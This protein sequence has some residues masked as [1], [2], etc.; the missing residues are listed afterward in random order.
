MNKTK[1]VKCKV[2]AV[3]NQKGGVG[4]STTAEA[5]A[6]GLSRK[7]YKALL[8]DLDPQGSITLASGVRDPESTTYELLVG[9]SAVPHVRPD[10]SDLIPAHENLARIDVEYATT[11]GREHKLQEAIEKLGFLKKYEYI[12]LDTPPALG[13]I[14]VNALTAATGVIIPAQADVYSLQGISQFNETVGAIKA[15]TNETI[16]I[17]GILLTRY[18]SRAILSRN[19]HTA[20]ARAAADMKTRLYNAVIRDNVALKEAQARQKS[21][22]NYAP[23]SNAAIDYM[24][25]TGEFLKSCR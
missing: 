14:T 19:M 16:K 2:I 12:I 8:L 21:I 13:I 10:R 24:A 23:K 20:A 17:Y 7:G 6:D 22:Y 15:Y 4:K 18:N 1:N 11:T 9:K 5:L 25:F 3:A